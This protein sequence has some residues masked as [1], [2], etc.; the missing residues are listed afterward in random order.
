VGAERERIKSLPTPKGIFGV[1]LLSVAGGILFSKG[2]AL[3]SFQN[4]AIAT[5]WSMA[6]WYSQWYGNGYI[7]YFLDRK[8]PWLEFPIKRLIIGF[9]SLITFS[10]IAILVVNISFYRV[11]YGEF[12]DTLLNWIVFNGKVS[13]SISL[14]ISTL[15]TSIGFFNSWRKSANKEEKLKVEMLDYKYKTLV[16][17]VNPHFLFNS[18]NVLTSLVY[19]DQDL[20]VKFIRQLSK[21][22]RYTLENK[23]RDLVSLKEEAAYI[24]SYVFLLKIRFEEALIVDMKIPKDENRF[25][26]PMALQIIVE[27]AIKHNNI[28]EKEPL[29]IKIKVVEDCLVV[30]N[31]LQLPE[32]KSE[33]TG[34]G[35]ENIQKRL[36]F[37]TDKKL[38]ITTTDGQFIV[39]IPI[40]TPLQ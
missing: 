4:F 40:L 34:F 37:L 24:D 18:L 5:L 17:Q 9:L 25:L 11:I 21:V 27:N 3:N 16:N 29:R 26:I 35:L 38:R 19:E 33:S 10:F 6:I 22:Y 20:A 1:F 8:W 13:V 32:N 2:Y 30:E 36:D 12:P 31:N 39:K 15:L 7:I 28:S 14:V 23:E